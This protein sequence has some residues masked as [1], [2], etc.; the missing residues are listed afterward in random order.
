MTTLGSDNG[1]VIQ[2]HHNGIYSRNNS[3]SNTVNSNPQD[4]NSRNYAPKLKTIDYVSV[5]EIGRNEK[6]QKTADYVY[7]KNKNAYSR[8][9]NHQVKAQQSTFQDIKQ[10]K[11]EISMKDYEL[12]KVQMELD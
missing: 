4:R 9:L 3:A 2:D 6:S 11:K 8:Q 10:I 7:Q 5:P 1:R 12:Q